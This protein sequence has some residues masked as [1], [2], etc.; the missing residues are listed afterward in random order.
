MSSADA[1]V[2]S[3]SSPMVSPADKVRELRELSGLS[4]EQFAQKRLGISSKQ[5]SRI[6]NGAPIGKKAAEALAEYSGLPAAFF[7]GLETASEPIDDDSIPFAERSLRQYRYPEEKEAWIRE[8][9]PE[10]VFSA[11]ATPGTIAF[12]IEQLA[13]QYEL[14]LGRKLPLPERDRVEE[15]SRL[16]PGALKRRRKPKK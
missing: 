2:L 4:Q 10:T 11:G 9:M 15:P 14:E 16:P 5:L 3:Y 7:M 12:T 13:T 1:C 6:E 8:R